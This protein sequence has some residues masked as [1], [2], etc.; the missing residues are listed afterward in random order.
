M[1][2]SDSFFVDY[3]ELSDEELIDKIDRNRKETDEHNQG[4]LGE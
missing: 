1:S 3:D 4:Q 2:E